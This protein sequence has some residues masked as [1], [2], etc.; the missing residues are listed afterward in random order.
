[1]EKEHCDV[2]IWMYIWYIVHSL[3]SI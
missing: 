1:L 2:N 3:R